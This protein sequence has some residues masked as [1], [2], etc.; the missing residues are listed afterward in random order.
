MGHWA[1]IALAETLMLI[2]IYCLQHGE[3]L[4]I[5]NEGKEGNEKRFILGG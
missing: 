5:R 3:G 2:C 1:Y 4:K